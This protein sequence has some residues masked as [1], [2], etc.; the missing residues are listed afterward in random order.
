MAVKQ[1][2]FG[3]DARQKM[4]VGINKLADAV[5]VTLGPRGRNVAIDKAWGSPTVIHD[6]VSVAKE[7]EL[8]D[9]FENMGAQLVKEAAERTNDA[10][11]DGTTT[12]TLLAQKL[13]SKGMRYVTAGT[14]PM[15]MKKGIDKA[16]DAVVAE[17]R[18]LAKPVS[19]ADWQKVATISA[20][21]EVIGEKIAEALKLVGKDGVVEVEEGKTMDI[22]I[23][24]KEGMEFD[25]GFAS[26]YF[27]T[28]SDSM[29]AVIESPHILVTDQKITNIQELLP[30]LESLV[31]VSKNFVIL[32]EDIE[33]E[34]L[35]TLVV[36]KL[37]GTFNGLAVKAPG[38]GDRRK[39]MLEDIAILTG[40]NFIST[41]TGRKLKD[42]TIE[43]LG[44]ADSV[45]SN[46]DTTRIVGGKGT[47]ADIDARVAQIENEIE[48]STSDFDI[49]KLQERKAKLT[50]GVAVIQV[51]A[52]TEVEMK[53]L[54]ERVK[55]AKE[56]TKAA[57]E[58]GITPGG[59][60]T[61]IQA[62]KVLDKLKTDGR[63]EEL[64]VELVK[65]VLQEPIRMLAKN[66]GFDPGF[67]I[68]EV[69]RQDSATFGFNALTNEFGD[70]VEDGV[71]EPAKV[72]TSALINA[73]SV[74][75]MILTTECLI[76]EAP[77]DEPAMPA[78]GMGGMGGGMPGMM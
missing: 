17:I 51:G 27:V 45:R 19:E 42:V 6:G 24:H 71:I 16:V 8:E 3:D 12:A 58:E 28:N 74:G 56:A 5:T 68:G 38:F 64:G 46:K 26:P 44:R 10:T 2:K 37:R 21:N 25:K 34:A 63:D 29:E 65:S 18:R 52:A 54:Q 40:A 39:A 50:G 4:L 57:I 70:L 73:A 72:A 15:M 22:T 48:K 41:D 62:S 61:F 9:K 78:G 35:T 31:K 33:G 43:D 11:G 66:S 14:N 77:K 23:E 76:T 55:D 20:Q 75:S 32:A 7:I 60:V 59:G 53:N 67:V 13:T 49:E 36:N 1:L 47:Q 30:M 69:N